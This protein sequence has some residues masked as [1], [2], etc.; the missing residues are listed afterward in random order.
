MSKTVRAKL[1]CL[2]QIIQLFPQ[3][4]YE[5][6][7][8][9]YL[10]VNRLAKLLEIIDLSKPALFRFEE[11]AICLSIYGKRFFRSFQEL[12]CFHAK[13]APIPLELPHP[14]IKL[15]QRTVIAVRWAVPCLL[16]SATMQHATPKCRI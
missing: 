5:H 13:R 15:A 10:R 4:F 7:S 12:G 2:F 8:I 16:F 14:T 9:Y 1:K 6:L 3:L 11:T